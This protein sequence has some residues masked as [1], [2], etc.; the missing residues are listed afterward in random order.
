MESDTVVGDPRGSYVENDVAPLENAD[1]AR[2]LG[3]LS[4]ISEKN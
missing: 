3:L 2:V 4:E 1:D